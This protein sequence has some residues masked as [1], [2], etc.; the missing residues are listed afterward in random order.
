MLKR[1]R[2]RRGLTQVDLAK[3]LGT[4]QQWVAKVESGERRLDVIEFSELATVLGI[5]TKRFLKVLNTVED[6]KN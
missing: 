3:L 5:D 2:K 6:P 4:R 1:A